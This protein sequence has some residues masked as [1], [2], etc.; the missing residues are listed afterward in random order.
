MRPVRW[1]V[2]SIPSNDHVEI[3]SRAGYCPDI[4]TRPRYGRIQVVGREDGT[5]IT[6][7][8]V[9]SRRKASTKIKFCSGIE[10]ILT[11]TIAIDRDAYG[12]KLYD[13]STNPPTLRG[14]LP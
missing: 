8:M 3:M 5:Y 10:A 14:Q 7:F 4:E 6:A 12:P 2:F 11:R 1:K 9:P 13:A